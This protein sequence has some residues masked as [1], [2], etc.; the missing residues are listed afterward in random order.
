MNDAD[1]INAIANKQLGVANTPQAGQ[2]AGVPP[3]A[4]AQQQAPQSP[5]ADPAPTNMEKA[6]A[7]VAPTDQAKEDAAVINF[8]KVGD[9]EYTSQQIEG[10]MNRYRD[11]N[12]RWQQNKPIVDVV[13]RMLEVSKKAGYDAKPEEV[14]Q[15]IE[16]ATQAYLKDPQLGSKAKP[17]TQ[18]G[19]PKPAMSDDADGEGEDGAGD[20]DAVYDKWQKENAVSLPPGFKETVTSTKQMAQKMDQM[21]SMFQQ[22]LQGGMAGQQATQQAQQQVQQAQSMKADAVTTMIANNLGKAFQ[23]AGL[24]ADPESRAAFR[25]FAASRG[26]DFPDFMDAGLTATVVGDYKANL[27]APE[28][29]RLREIA[30]KRQAFTGITGATPTGGAPAAQGGDATLNAMISSAMQSKG[31]R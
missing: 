19:G 9:R 16:A 6:Q 29:Q 14:A 20:I 1:I 3:E 21:M 31:M 10:T 30:Q 8:V 7:K 22:I 28:M 18:Q 26:Y 25:A 27:N 24:P 2:P 4:A 13:E 12:F 15:L 5:K 11:L 17:T 23:Q